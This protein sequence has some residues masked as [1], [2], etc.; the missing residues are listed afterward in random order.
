MQH[1]C[2]SQLHIFELLARFVTFVVPKTIIN[3]SHPISSSYEL[4]DEY[5]KYLHELPSQLS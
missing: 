1:S 5:H 4:I 2:R 3:H